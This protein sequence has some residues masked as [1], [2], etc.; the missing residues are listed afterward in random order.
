MEIK[1]TENET[2]IKSFNRLNL[3]FNM[4]KHIFAF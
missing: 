3:Y 4:V 1:K 2:V